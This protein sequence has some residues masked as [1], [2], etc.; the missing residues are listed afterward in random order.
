MIHFSCLRGCASTPHKH[1]PAG[2]E[3]SPGQ[4]NP[5]CLQ[6]L[7]VVVLLLAGPAHAQDWQPVIDAK[8]IAALFSETTHTAT[9]PGDNQA[10]A[11]YNA[12]GT[13]PRFP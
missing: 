4:G 2:H 9:L 11:K 10:V 5:L 8:E 1:D 13:V 6:S 3:R 12:D 7:A